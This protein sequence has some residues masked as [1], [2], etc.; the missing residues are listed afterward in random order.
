MLKIR[1]L[2]GSLLKISD[3]Q[4]AT[5]ENAT[6]AIKIKHRIW[7]IGSAIG[8]CKTWA[9][10]MPIHLAGGL[11]K[12]ALLREQIEAQRGDLSFRYMTAPPVLGALRLATRLAG[13]SPDASFDNAFLASVGAFQ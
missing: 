2:R 8:T 7:M 4:D 9:A 12:D 5:W 1:T 11:A 10:R 3:R 6:C 13:D